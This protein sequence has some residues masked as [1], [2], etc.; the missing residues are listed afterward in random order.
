MKAERVRADQSQL[1]V[2]P[3]HDALMRAAAELFV[4]ASIDAIGASDRFAVALSGGATPQSLYTLLATDAYASRIDWSRVHIFWGDERSVPPSSPESNY[5]RARVAL[6]AR[7]PVPAANVHRIRGEDE[8]AAAAAAYERKLRELFRT[9][10]GAPRSTTG[11]RFDLILLG[12]GDDGHTASLFPGS[13]TLHETRRWVMAEEF[14][15]VSISRV[16]LTPVVINAASEVLFLV[17]GREKSA[18]LKRVLEGPRQPDALPAQAIA[19]SA[20]R[21]RWL[22]DAD[23]AA[24]L[25]AK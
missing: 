24:D 5:R 4:A 20:G 17:S 13:A 21:L 22:V 2:F 8:P 14:A 18:T 23:A 3:T 25:A 10:V 6:L 7:V 12:L 9:P 15:D 19:P 1:D 16:T 11:A